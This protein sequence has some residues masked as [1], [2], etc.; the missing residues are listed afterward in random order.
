M[1]QKSYLPHIEQKQNIDL[2]T[3]I[4]KHASD[5][6]SHIRSDDV[7]PVSEG[8]KTVIVV[9]PET[10]QNRHGTDE[11]TIHQFPDIKLLKIAFV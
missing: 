2:T 9:R 4:Y 8:K 6:D 11:H 5:D 7:T 1:E 3:P 10:Q